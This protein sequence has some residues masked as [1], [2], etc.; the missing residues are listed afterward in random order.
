MDTLSRPCGLTPDE[1]RRHNNELMRLFS[2]YLNVGPAAVG[3]ETVREIAD[4]C[5][6]PAAEA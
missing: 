2:A 6:V 4:A 3:G 1:I 5:H